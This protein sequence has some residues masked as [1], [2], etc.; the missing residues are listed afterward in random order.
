MT[1]LRPLAAAC[2][3]A[4]LAA[5]AAPAP[6]P[7]R[8][9]AASSPS[10]SPS[11]PPAPAA[12]AKRTFS[13]DFLFVLTARTARLEPG[14]NGG[15]G[16]RI[17]LVDAA[18]HAVWFT[19]KPSR[20]AGMFDT[21]YFLGVRHWGVEGGKQPLP[22]TPADAV[23]APPPR[24][25]QPG[26]VSNETGT[27]L[28]TPNAVLVA[29]GAARREA[30]QKGRA[31]PGADDTALAVSIAGVEM[32]GADVVVNVTVISPDSGASG[33]AGN[34]LSAA[35]VG[36]DGKGLLSTLTRTTLNN[37]ALFIDDYYMEVPAS[38][39]TAPP[40]P[41]PPPPPAT[42][43]PA[44]AAS[45]YDAA[46][47]RRISGP[48]PVDAYGCQFTGGCGYGGYGGGAYGW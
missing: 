35:Q 26:F 24:P 42:P 37:V 21:A 3:L 25:S 1:L 30:P 39:A 40:P 48:Q 5:A 44:D 43:S 6:A 10:P 31:P 7:M 13:A 45:A 11:P 23:A 14:G 32:R 20:G 19:D 17:V 29:G 33:V 2:A 18:P 15:G 12:T 16:G 47:W 36:K 27:W 22:R 9:S 8:A 38:V 34:Y 28:G 41:P 46:V 4:A